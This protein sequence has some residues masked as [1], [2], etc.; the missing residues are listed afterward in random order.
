[1]NRI[2]G[3]LRRIGLDG[4]AAPEITMDTLGRIQSGCVTHIAYENI[5]ILE[6]RA[7]K[8]DM[9]SLY[10]K[11]VTG[12]R[13]GYC[14]ELNGLL[15]VMLR[16][17][18]LQVSERFARY[19][20]GETQLPMRR[21]RV[22]IVRMDDCDI[23]MDIGVGQTA[24]RLPLKIEADTVQTQNGETYRFTRDAQNNWVLWDLHH[25]NWREY[26]AFGD[27]PAYDVDFVQPSFYCEKHPDSPFNK[28][29]MIAI[30]TSDGR[31]TIDGRCYKVFVGEDIAHIEDGISD[32]RLNELLKNEFMLNV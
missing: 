1:M 24:P 13:G 17:M 32:E 8:L 4:D 15:T 21:H 20:R 10:E 3:F 18:G 25:G 29:Y 7:L 12:G 23:L 31:R 22:T 5:D 14:F 30:K 11:I 9:D 16:E 26:I 6:G 2:R 19:L 27:E 28:D